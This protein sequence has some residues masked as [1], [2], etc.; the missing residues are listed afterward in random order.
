MHHL[1]SERK[2]KWILR[3]LNF[4]FLQI[5]AYSKREKRKK[6]RLTSWPLPRKQLPWLTLGAVCTRASGLAYCWLP[7]SLCCG[8]Q[9]VIWRFSGSGQSSE[10]R[11]TVSFCTYSRNI[12]EEQMPSKPFLNTPNL[13]SPP[14][15]PLLSL[16]FLPLSSSPLSFPIFVLCFSFFFSAPHTPQRKRKRMTSGKSELQVHVLKVVY[17][18]VIWKGKEEEACLKALC[19][20][21]VAQVALCSNWLKLPNCLFRFC[22]NGKRCSFASIKVIMV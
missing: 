11:Y 4:I 16:L 8:S 21:R 2:L 1:A 13:K 22:K 12:W 6:N 10:A 3:I 7:V 17:L 5:G 15:W 9:S 20:Q 19:L 18:L 14:L